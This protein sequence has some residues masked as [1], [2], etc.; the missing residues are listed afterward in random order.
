MNFE[1]WIPNVIDMYNMNIHVYANI[2]YKCPD[3]SGCKWCLHWDSNN[4]TERLLQ[5]FWTL[6]QWWNF[7]PLFFKSCLTIAIKYF[8][9][10][11]EIMN[12]PGVQ[13][14]GATGEAFVSER[15]ISVDH[16]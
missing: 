1:W 8:S 11:L 5:L 12:H 16:N 6:I 14:P 9:C 10:G 15:N 13:I 2:Y 4:E 7:R 3:I